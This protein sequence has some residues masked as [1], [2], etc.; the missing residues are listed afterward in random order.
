MK[1]KS[2]LLLMIT[3][4]LQYFLYAKDS[5]F[6]L[7]SFDDLKEIKKM[8]N[9][10]QDAEQYDK[11]QNFSSSNIVVTFDDDK[12]VP[13]IRPGRSSRVSVD[14]IDEDISVCQALELETMCISR[15]RK[16]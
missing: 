10:E 3:C 8:T 7:P 4:N 13:D 14:F 11:V 2:I 12:E 15:I 6:N 16:F 5:I 1:L 9:N